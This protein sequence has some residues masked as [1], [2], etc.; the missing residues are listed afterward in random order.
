MVCQGYPRKSLIIQRMAAL[1][2]T[3]IHCYISRVTL[4]WQAVLA[5]ASLLHLWAFTRL[6][7]CSVIQTTL[8]PNTD[9]VHTMHVHTY[10]ALWNNKTMETQ[11]NTGDAEAQLPFLLAGLHHTHST[12]TCTQWEKSA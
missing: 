4:G 12:F 11:L 2:C 5:G 8:L 1:Q 3:R 10:K 9:L 6:F 7:S